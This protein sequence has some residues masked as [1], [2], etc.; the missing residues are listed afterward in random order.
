[1]TP[2]DLIAKLATRHG[3]K[4]SPQDPVL[5]VAFLNDLILSDQ[6]DRARGLMDEQ[7]RGFT[8]ELTGH[9]KV[10]E[11]EIGKLLD[12][13]DGDLGRRVAA[14]VA[15]GIDSAGRD[16][17]ERMASTIEG[18]RAQAEAAIAH[19]VG[20]AQLAARGAAHACLWAVCA[21]GIAGVIAVGLVVYAGMPLLARMI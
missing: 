4:I 3:I 14:A 7:F 12:A 13:A 1:V 8:R 9:Q 6:L 21:A 20:E 11:A 19:L 15:G 2:D 5:V 17:R 18:G 10:L 16:A